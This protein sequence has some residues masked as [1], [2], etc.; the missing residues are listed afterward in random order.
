VVDV[1]DPAFEDHI[2]TVES[3]IMELDVPATPRVLLWNKADSVPGGHKAVQA[4]A[5]GGLAISAID[6]RT[7]APVLARIRDTLRAAA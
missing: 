7:L 1:S 5:R 6:P 2:R 3:L 4:R